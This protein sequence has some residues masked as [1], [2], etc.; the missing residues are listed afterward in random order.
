MAEGEGEGTNR[1]GAEGGSG[2]SG[3]EGVEAEEGRRGG[4]GTWEGS[5]GAATAMAS[6]FEAEE[7]L[8]VEQVAHALALAYVMDQVRGVGRDGWGRGG[9]GVALLR[10]WRWEERMSHRRKFMRREAVPVDVWQPC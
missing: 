10:G 7:E 9:A 5:G 4:G 2:E 8:V 3:R 6:P 1:R